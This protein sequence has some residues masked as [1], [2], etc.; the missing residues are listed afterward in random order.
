MD[1]AGGRRHAAHTAPG[2]VGLKTGHRARFGRDFGAGGA[3]NGTP[4]TLEREKGAAGR[5]LA[6]GETKMDRP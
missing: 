6:A 4:D 2:Q 1:A 5:D 3:E